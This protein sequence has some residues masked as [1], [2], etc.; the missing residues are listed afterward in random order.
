MNAISRRDLL[1][2]LA[3]GGVIA[4]LPGAFLAGSGREVLQ[5]FAT[6]LNRLFSQER[7][8]RAIGERY[9]ARVPDE[10]DATILTARVAGDMQGYLRLASADTPTLR[11]LL[12][13]QQRDDFAHGR[14][15]TIDGWVLSCTEARLCALVTLAS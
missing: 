5:P 10:A 9:L 8:A 6:R 3:L 2:R 7:S 4:A 1:K 13:A 14:T 12:A 15:V 11:A